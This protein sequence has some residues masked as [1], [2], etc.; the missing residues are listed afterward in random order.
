MSKVLL[1]HMPNIISLSRI[2]LALI[3]FFLGYD[4][5]QSSGVILV[6][7]LA[8]ITDFFDGL[9]ARWLNS[10][11]EFG[12]RLDPCADAIFLAAIFVLLSEKLGLDVYIIMLVLLRYTSIA[13]MQLHRIVLGHTNV[14][15]LDS[16]KWTLAASMLWIVFAML[17]NM[18]FVYSKSAIY[19]CNAYQ[20]WWLGIMLLSWL[21]YFLEYKNS[22]AMSE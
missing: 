5:L 19:F 18:S 7:I 15:A 9:A 1:Q 22:M 12:R 3:V 16:G 6:T 8:A 10:E 20:L 4:Y 17:N 2:L 14:Q 11:T 13:A 21:D